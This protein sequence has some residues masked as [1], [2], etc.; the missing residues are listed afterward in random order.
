M[1]SSYMLNNWRHWLLA[2]SLLSIGTRSTLAAPPDAPKSADV[3]LL[4][5][6]KVPEAVSQSLQDHDYLAAIKA[7]DAAAEAKDAAKDYLAY[8]KGRALHLAGQDDAAIAQFDR[9]AKEFP[10][11]PWARRA[12]FGKALA[13]AHKGDFH[14]AEMIYRAEVDYLLSPARKNELAGIYLEFADTYFKPK[15][16]VQHQPDY[17]KALDFYLKA[18]ADMPAGARRIEV[19]L[20]V[21]RCYQL[22][23]QLPE[24]AKRYGQFV[25]DHPDE[26]MEIE[27]RF[28]LGEVQLAQSQPQ[29]AR[30]TWQDLLAAHPDSS[31]QRIAEAAYNLSLTYGIPNPP[32]DEDL[33]LG[34]AALESFVKKYPAHKLAAQA[35]LRIAE[36][37][38][39]RGRYDNAVKS[40]TGFLADPRYADREELADARNLLGRSYQLQRNFTAALAAWREYLVKHPSHHAWSQVQQQI[41]DTEYLM[42]AD[43]AKDRK[44]GEARRLWDEFLA[45]YPLDPRDPRILYLFGWMDFQQDKLVGALGDWRRLVSKYPGT[46][47][48]SRGQYMIAVTLETKLN[49]LEAALKEYRKVAS[50]SFVDRA[51][52]AIAR[53]TA[54]SL[55]IAT[56]RVFRTDEMPKIHLDTR[57][58]ESVTV[59]AYHVDLEAYFRKMHV[60]RGVEGL[61]IALI[62]PDRTFEF[63]VPKYTEYQELESEVE[64]GGRGQGPGVRG[65]GDEEKTKKAAPVYGA[66]A[67]TVSSKTLE[68]T[69][70]VLQS[71]LDLIVKSSRDELFVFAENMRTGKP[72]P[73][74]RLLISNGQQ[75]FAEGTTGPDGVFKQ[76]Y[77]ELHDAADVR[78]LGLAEGGVASNIVS[79]QGIGVAQGL[80]DKAYIYTD[81]P[82]YRAGD[83]VHVRGVLRRAVDDAYTIE[84]GKKFTLEVI[85]GRSRS[86]WQEELVLSKFGS[87]HSHLMLPATS[88]V[89]TYRIRVYDAD[90]H[91]YE[92]AFD[93]REYQ[94]EP[95]RLAVET[96]RR[97]YYRGEPIEGR[98]TASFYYGA[99]LAGREVHYQILGQPETIATTD[100]KGEVRFKI[101]TRDFSESE[102]LHFHY[103]LPERNLS[104]VQ[105]FFIAAEGF[106]FALSTVRPVFVAGESFELTV[107]ALDAEQKPLAEKFLLHVIERTVV[108]GKVGERQFEEFE[109]TTDAKE[110]IARQTLHVEQGGQYIFRAEGIDR[111]KNTVT[112]QHVVRI[113][114]DKDQVRLRILA[115][116]H[117]FKVGDTAEVQLHWREAPA[118]ALVTFQGA[119]V[120]DYRLVK[121]ETGA[122]KLPIP[123]AARL[124]PNFDLNVA[125]MTDPRGAVVE[126]AKAADDG[127][128]KPQAELLPVEKVRPR[129]FHEASSPFTVDRPLAIALTPKRKAGAKGPIQPGEEI[130]LVI[131]ATDPQGKPVSAELS[132]GLVQQSLLNLFGSNVAPIDDIFRGG[133]RQS[134]LR[135]STSATFAYYPATRPIDSQLLSESER[136]V[137]A[138]EESE[139]KLLHMPYINR[140]FPRNRAG[141][142]EGYRRI[143]GKA[144]GRMNINTMDDADA[145]FTLTTRSGSEAIATPRIV[146]QESEEGLNQA[147]ASVDQ[148]SIPFV[149]ERT[150]S[151]G[152]VTYSGSINGGGEM[153]TGKLSLGVGVNSD[154]GLVGKITT[155]SFDLPGRVADAT[156]LTKDEKR[157]GALGTNANMD[158]T[159]T[160]YKTHFF[161]N[162]ISTGFD[163][164]ALGPG[165][166]IKDGRVAVLGKDGVF[167]TWS[168][169]Y[170]ASMSP[171]SRKELIAI[172]S[173][174]LR[175]A[176]AVLISLR[177]LQETGYWNPA[178]LTDEK[179][180]ATITITMPDQS[181]AWKLS[182]KGITADTL[183]GEAETDLTA[184]KELFGELKLPPALT[185]GDDAQIQVTVH[186][187]ILEKGPITVTLKTTIGS[188]TVEEHKTIDAISK[189]PAEATFAIAVRRPKPDAAK[190]AGDKPADNAPLSP[191]GRGAGGEGASADEAAFE[192]TVAAAG[193]TDVVR[194][195]VPI[196][197]FGMPVYATAS[198]SASA[199]ATVWVEAPPKMPLAGPSL[200]VLIGPSVERSL[201]DVLFA[202]A[203]ACQFDSLRV[204]SG[205]DSTTSDLLAALAVQKLMHS[206]RDSGG[207]HAAALDARIRGAVSLLVSSQQEDG[208]WSWTGRGTASHRLT[209]ARV[210]WAVT[211]A[212][213]AGYKVPDD[214]FE[215]AVA[216]LQSQVATTGQT[217]Y[218]SKAVLLQALAVAGQGDFT[219][220]NRLYRNRPAL[221]TV[222]L[223]DLALALVEMDHK[224]MAADLLALIAER[225]LDGTELI[226]AAIDSLPWSRSAVE[227]RAL[228]ALALESVEPDSPKIKEQI[229]WLL[230]HRSGNRWSPD[231]AT[232]PATAALA[233]WFSKNRFDEE[234]YQLTV[235]VNDLKAGTLDIDPKSLTQTI[236]VPARMLKGAGR[237]RINFQLTGRGR[238]T[239]EAILSGF[240]AADK[241]QS[242]TKDWTVRR[243]Y[244]PAPLE[245]DGREI[246]RGFGVLQGS[247]ATFRNP[248]AHLAVGRR[249]H[250]ELEIWRNAPDGDRNPD[251]MGYLV[252]TEPLSSGTTV[253]ESSIA[254]G[255]ERYE[256]G[257]GE[258]TFYIGSR[259]FVEPIHFDVHGYL[260]GQYRAGPTVV[261]DAYRLDQIAVS[262]PHELTVMSLGAKG[263]DPYRLTPEE[264]FQFG[265]RLFEKGEYAR[266]GPYLAELLAKWNVNPDTYK[267]SARMLLDIHLQNGPPAEIVRYF[268]II[269]ERWP[270]LEL[271]FE[272]IIKVAAA[273][274]E[275]GEYERS[276][277]VYRATTEGSFGRES[278]VAGFLEGE[279]EF[280]RSVTVM[281]RLL[282]EYPP[283]P[284]VAAAT[285]ALSQRVYAYAP[286][287]AT[288]QKL[289]AKKI[290]RVDLIAQALAMVDHFLSEYPNDPAAD[291]A[292]FS[293]A[294]ALL[295][296]KAYKEVIARATKFA[297]RYPT[298]NYLDSFWYIVAYGH[299]ALGQDQEALVMAQKVSEAKR[300]D[301]QTGREVESPNKW[302]AIYIMGQ[303]YHSLGQAAKAIAEYTRVEDRFADAKQAIAYFTRQEIVMPEV[304]VVRPKEP[305]EVELKFRNIA[306]VDVKV[307]RIDLMKFSLLKR[308][309]AGITQINLAGIRPSF[310]T[311][312]Q[313]GDGK[314]YRD[315]THKLALPLTDEGAYLVVCRGNDLYASGLV[316]ISPLKIEVQE[317]APSGQVRVTV[318][319]VATDSYVSNVHVKVIGS[320]NDDFVSGQ[321]DLR[322]VFVAQGLKGTSTA[323][324]ETDTSRYAFFRGETN[325][326]P[327]VP[328]P[329][330]P[331]PADA[332]IDGKA[333][334]PATADG[335]GQLLQNIQQGN[336]MIQTD[337]GTKLQN[338][339]KQDTKGVK[340]KEAY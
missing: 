117:T 136:L 97:V 276:Y 147:M 13:L 194:R 340:A 126:D 45:K 137:L 96:D 175:N 314:D 1:A 297:A 261:R 224:P 156:K 64:V 60:I 241:L 9:F 150:Y 55:S 288:D 11:S 193:R 267:D 240:V 239:F 26:A 251:Q 23:N 291:Q 102:T 49:Q 75:V 189:G 29:D 301:K 274:H 138:A 17:K 72:W 61:D 38:I 278:A 100:E 198:G 204:A 283:E 70:L 247:F 277:L 8:L 180:E 116:R 303:V 98:I 5:L 7:I 109:L 91:S 327:Q 231:K 47:D 228:Y 80:A 319:N 46:E 131:T 289:R 146:V 122:N 106:S 168:F 211:M 149:T 66:M 210:L 236:D 170:Q 294:N 213:R 141:L 144:D 253:I 148:S 218:E 316:L 166:E 157:L 76:S 179:G 68:A 268:E 118:L 37:Y 167:D 178:I 54:K 77:K 82:V 15:D 258:I 53:L 12:R 337:N 132:L 107:K 110:G 173:E 286:Q 41:V 145:Y 225:K 320:R 223:A 71:D 226:G 222:A 187:S 191:R 62:D 125:V 94:L 164:G 151:G 119:R 220:A 139:H 329:A 14:A 134:A 269:K 74:V 209:S 48:A 36:S 112:G 176:G 196:H 318:K 227:V 174:Q 203:P 238:Y 19:E 215:K 87:F 259:P 233:Q 206:S 310:A 4:P 244:E 101:P 317:D 290:N 212:K 305:A 22:L 255:F 3:E 296:L 16:D 234:H 183:C 182:A 304:S 58:I 216:Y 202:P 185:D 271:P 205:L 190:P 50:G 324:A 67:V 321:T 56:E 285:F 322:G 73:G 79:L 248:L 84:A 153:Q 264:L 311:T 260:P 113:S 85:D 279:G 92:G 20:Q 219:L 186:N 123:M 325:L 339:Y 114:D 295:E 249:G 18:L 27:A 237:Q 312:L 263:V 298:S 28:R 169:A 273:Y 214:R 83:L 270:D 44:F 81:R 306:T 250:V 78:V 284:Y 299:F 332:V 59:R 172:R 165:P 88:P 256:I 120:L 25:K 57:N 111:F 252:V 302:E 158:S 171:E 24:A 143:G 307:Y 287:A 275:M 338:I 230:A 254:G 177:G 155:D 159:A 336:S 229:D 245:L 32:T 140:L 95:I 281:N 6:P 42:A 121:L 90:N 52:F 127:R 309:L 313:L 65:Q 35:Q 331:A 105:D 272:K 330:K 40:L 108:D 130:E 266:S 63:A 30:R 103:S 323:I 217:D 326:G 282:A 335:Q 242:T 10:D 104:G 208:G 39:A 160:N 184:K 163:I 133:A 152:T 280:L 129:R 188:K 333:G 300:L 195:V 86:I 142:D 197:P 128:A 235:F 257:S 154:A 293:E 124:A 51:K 2:I 99:P 162:G 200:Q 199:D 34:V 334:Q 181:T 43:K 69:T 115:D 192:L 161:A 89:G 265:K 201:L 21:A 33:N 243:S 292:A 31:S 232:G 135:T 262:E 315:R 308:N 246:P 328:E 93:V 207:P 221:S